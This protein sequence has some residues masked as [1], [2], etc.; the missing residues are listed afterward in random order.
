VRFVEVTLGGW[1]THQS[2]FIRVPERT[3][4][5][6][7][8]LGTLLADLRERGLLEK[9]LVVVASE[10]GRTP[11]INQNAGRDHY[12]RAF[13][14]LLAG[15]GIKG[16]VAYGKTDEKGVDVVENQ[17]TV[18]QFNATIAQALGLPM[19]KIVT[20]PSRRPFIVADKAEPIRELL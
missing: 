12:P 20:S 7:Q 14:G 4:I 3:A 10:F 6:D 17:V 15:G 1:D 13:S 9:T 18:P 19:K 11:N 5:L 8:A 2:N 16:S